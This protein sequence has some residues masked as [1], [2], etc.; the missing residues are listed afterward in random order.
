MGERQSSPSS[1]YE[2]RSSSLAAV[3]RLP[4]CCAVWRLICH[5]WPLVLLQVPAELQILLFFPPPIL[6]GHCAIDCRF[7][8]IPQEGVKLEP[9][10]EP[11]AEGPLLL[12]K[13]QLPPDGNPYDLKGGVQMGAEMWPKRAAKLKKST[14]KAARL[15]RDGSASANV[16]RA[17]AREYRSHQD[18]PDSTY[19][20]HLSA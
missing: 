16:A 2:G 4:A 9:T 19:V 1:G 20:A 18:F 10:D 12:P 5:E 15:S 8:D 11:V 6:V 13:Y 3:A 14:Q 7:D 17:P